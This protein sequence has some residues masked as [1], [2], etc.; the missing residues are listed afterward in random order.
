MKQAYY[1]VSPGATRAP[2]FMTTIEL[3]AL[4]SFDAS[5]VAY[6]VLDG[7]DEDLPNTQHTIRASQNPLIYLRPIVSLVSDKPRNAAPSQS[8]RTLLKDEFDNEYAKKLLSSF[9]PINH[10]IENLPAADGSTDRNIALRVLRFMASRSKEFSPI[11]TSSD[12]HGFLYPVLEPLFAIRDIGTIETLQYL[13]GQRLLQGRFFKQA[14]FCSS[15]QSAFLNFEEQCPHCNS[16]N[17]KIDELVHHFKCAY[18]GELSEFQ[19]GNHLSCPKCEQQLRHIG[20]DYDKPSIIYHCNDC[21]HVF[22]DPEVICSC[23]NCGH[24][25]SPEDQINR[26]IEHYNVTS[27]GQNA[28]VYGMESLFSNILSTDLKLTSE[29]VFKEYLKLESAR[30]SRYKLSTTS[31]VLVN[32][33]ELDEIYIKLGD[34]AKDVFHELSAV[35][36]SILRTSDVITAINETLFLILMTETSANNAE[37]ALERLQQGV[38]ELMKSNLDITP[39]FDTHIEQIAANMDVTALLD[40]FLHEKSHVDRHST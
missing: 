23:Y 16:G 28:A 13:K 30:I 11:M 40:T 12:P 8:D 20:V 25:T 14:Y 1:I 27:L 38:T 39:A 32:I 15:C 37:R 17:L 18:T 2:Q 19:I 31:L 34:K 6:W 35:F 29:A 7:D 33:N 24:T 22:Q 26:T 9:H 36:K 10:W 5:N 4:E 3:N 21:T